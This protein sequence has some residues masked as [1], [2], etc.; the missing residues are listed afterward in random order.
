MQHRAAGVSVV[1]LVIGLVSGVALVIKDEESHMLSHYMSN[2]L[3]ANLI[4]V[5]I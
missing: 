4:K 3:T 1:G 2:I 5:V